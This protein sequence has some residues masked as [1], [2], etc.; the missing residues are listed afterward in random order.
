MAGLTCSFLFTF[1]RD[2]FKSSLPHDL[3]LAVVQSGETF[4]L[5]S[6][7]IMLQF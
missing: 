3:E 6:I 7:I 4:V 2:L 5:F 1:C